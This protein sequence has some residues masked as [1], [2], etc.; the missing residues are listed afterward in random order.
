MVM[1]RQTDRQRIDF[2][3]NLF[4]TKPQKQIYERFHELLVVN[5][6]QINRLR[7]AD[8]LFRIRRWKSFKPERLWLF[9]L[10]LFS[11]TF[12][13]FPVGLDIHTDLISELS[14]VQNTWA[15]HW[16]HLS[17]WIDAISIANLLISNIILANYGADSP[18][19]LHYHEL[20]LIFFTAR[21]A[22][23]TVEGGRMNNAVVDLGFGMPIKILIEKDISRGAPLYPI[24]ADVWSTFMATSLPMAMIMSVL[25]RSIFK[26]FIFF[27]FGYKS[28]F[29][30]PFFDELLGKS[31]RY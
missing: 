3:T 22:F 31:A 11:S 2:N 8:H 12:S 13:S 28:Y 17:R 30:I 25:L 10:S 15:Y 4:R 18:F 24:C 14:A 9:K 20:A 23:G 7:S 5:K 27:R 16:R 19:R 21:S 6:F 29:I 1:I 26:S